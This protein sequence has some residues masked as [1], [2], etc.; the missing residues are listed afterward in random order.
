MIP[1]RSST[2]WLVLLAF[3]ALLAVALASLVGHVLAT[4]ISYI[5]QEAIGTSQEKPDRN[6]A[7]PSSSGNSGPE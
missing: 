6:A 3:G 5:A 4:G 2:L 7:D 1:P